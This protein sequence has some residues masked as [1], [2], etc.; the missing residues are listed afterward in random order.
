MPISVQLLFWVSVT[1]SDNEK[2]LQVS[3]RNKDKERKLSLRPGSLN[4][5]R[6]FARSCRGFKQ[7]PKTKL[8]AS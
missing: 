8:K 4:L 1:I 5:D 3:L 2:P 6:A 7:F